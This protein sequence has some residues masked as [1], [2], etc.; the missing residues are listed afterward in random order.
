MKYNKNIKR[1]TRLRVV[2]EGEDNGKIGILDF[3]V[4][5]GCLLIINERNAGFCWCEV[6]PVGEQ[7]LLF[8]F[9]YE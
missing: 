7:Q 2:R 6:E 9:M 5:A 3:A 1:G 8:N 4:R